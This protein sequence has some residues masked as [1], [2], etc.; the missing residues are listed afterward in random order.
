[1][2]TTARRVRPLGAIVLATL[3]F[4]SQALLVKTLTHDSGIRPFQVIELRGWMQ[5][6]GCVLMF[7][8]KGTSPRDWL[9]VT[10]LQRRILCLRSFLGF[11][12]ISGGFSAIAL[13]PLG[14][15]ATLSQTAPVWASILAV[16]FLKEPWHPL[17]ALSAFGALCGV[18][19]VLRPA[20]VVALLG[21]GAVDEPS[22]G[23]AL[24]D[25]SAALDPT[26][27]LGVA[28][29][30]SGALSAAGV[31][32]VV[33]YLGTVIKTPLPTVV[34]YQGIGQALAAP[35]GG[36]VTGEQWVL[37]TPRQWLML[38][39]I[40]VLGFWSQVCL[41]YGLQ[42][43]K[44]ATATLFRS[45]EVLFAFTWQATLAPSA[46]EHHIMRTS[47]AGASL[48][49]CSMLCVVAAKARREKRGAPRADEAAHD[50]GGLLPAH[51]P[52]T[53]GPDPEKELEAGAAQADSGAGWAKP[54]DGASGAHR[55]RAVGGVRAQL[56]AA[57]H[58]RRAHAATYTE[59]AR[60][61]S[62][63][64]LRVE[65]TPA[66]A[67]T[68]RAAQPRSVGGA[69][70]SDSD[71]PSTAQAGSCA[72]PLGRV[73]AGRDSG[74]AEGAA[75]SA[76]PSGVAAAVPPMEGVPEAETEASRRLR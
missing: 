74:A 18:A 23:A 7:W 11:L 66:A 52:R 16:V 67:A 6:A 61:A 41:T 22:G 72:L 35:L 63:G 60:D 31:F 62:S 59:L 53:D 28:C 34:L 69:A 13:L 70:G 75:A 26:R 73:F 5:T 49:V 14:D 27:A 25:G 17:E 12:G 37:P 71:R 19:L 3:G 48:I 10:A 43:E 76:L 38:G 33:R 44:T 51:D 50:A 32:V 39:T 57:R 68:S 46:S 1:M 9:G 4:S 55:N 36:L 8:A 65:L 2:S 56:H 47:V 20:P 24:G 58:T 40:G 45:T 54:D 64:S 30:L 42:R 15:A 21:A 29:S